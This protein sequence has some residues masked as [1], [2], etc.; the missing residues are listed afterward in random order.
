MRCTEVICVPKP[1]C[2]CTYDVIE[3]VAEKADERKLAKLTL[4]T[5][6]P[7]LDSKVRVKVSVIFGSG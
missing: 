7:R 4:C 5:G 3:D 1:R 2:V 6:C